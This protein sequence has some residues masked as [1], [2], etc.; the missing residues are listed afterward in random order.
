MP[1]SALNVS[2]N[3]AFTTDDDG[4]EALNSRFNVFYQ[5]GL[6]DLSSVEAGLIL[7]TTNYLG[8]DGNDDSTLDLNLAYRHN[9]AES[10]DLVGGYVHT[11]DSENDSSTNRS[12]E[13][14][15]TIQ[16]SFWRRF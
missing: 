13:V 8:D 2:F 1:T 3:Q 16:K 9:L 14:F 6:T 12:D 5:K 15:L 4:N 11:I 7:R 10:W